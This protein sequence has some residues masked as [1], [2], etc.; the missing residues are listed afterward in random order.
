MHLPLPMSCLQ[1]GYSQRWCTAS[2]LFALGPPCRRLLIVPAV[3]LCRCETPKSEGVGQKV[4]FGV[5]SS[6]RTLRTLHTS[7]MQNVALPP[8]MVETWLVLLQPGVV[9]P[10]GCTDL[11]HSNTTLSCIATQVASMMISNHNARLHHLNI[12]IN[13]NSS[14]YR[15]WASPLVQR[16]GSRTG[17]V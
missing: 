7:E 17:L 1:S 16:A 10:Q 14:P 8:H 2:A 11:S 6:A 3:H 12:E 4:H 9:L 15:G 13:A 5:S